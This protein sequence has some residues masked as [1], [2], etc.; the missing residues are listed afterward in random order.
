ML[1][2]TQKAIMFDIELV[3]LRYDKTVISMENEDVADVLD[4]FGVFKS[5]RC[6]DVSVYVNGVR[7][8]PE[9]AAVMMTGEPIDELLPEKWTT[10]NKQVERLWRLPGFPRSLHAQAENAFVEWDAKELGRLATEILDI[11]DGRLE[12]EKVRLQRCREGL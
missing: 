3:P 4:R 5:V 12:R 11:L 9:F 6:R 7:L 2:G 1:S 10:F 8:E